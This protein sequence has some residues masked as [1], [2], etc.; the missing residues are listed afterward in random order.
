VGVAVG[1]FPI[2]LSSVCSGLGGEQATNRKQ[3]AI[4]AIIFSSIDVYSAIIWPVTLVEL[5]ISFLIQN[6]TFE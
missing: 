4:N 5:Q 1:W 2:G 3:A 6:I